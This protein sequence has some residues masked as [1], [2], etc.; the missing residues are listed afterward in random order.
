VRKN[1]TRKA[2]KI[3]GQIRKGNGVK[4]QY[5]LKQ[6]T[7]RR[8]GTPSQKVYHTVANTLRQSGIVAAH[9][10]GLI[11]ATGTAAVAIGRGTNAIVTLFI[12]QDQTITANG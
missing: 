11:L 6:K 4:L 7:G 5:R 9:P 8:S 1:I 12:A 3:V 2:A 10:A